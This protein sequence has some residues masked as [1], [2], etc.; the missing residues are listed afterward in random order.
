[1][2]R[3]RR[4]GRPVTYRRRAAAGSIRAARTAGSCQ[5]PTQQGP[6]PDALMVARRATLEKWVGGTLVAGGAAPIRTPARASCAAHP[7]V[8][9]T[10]LAHTRDVWT[11]PRYSRADVSTFSV[12]VARLRR[13]DLE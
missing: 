3:H 11:L 8:Y 6:L 5:R 9:T 2:S 12:V 1:M 13:W 10:P 4:I 7:W